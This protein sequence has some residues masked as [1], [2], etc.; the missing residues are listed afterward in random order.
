[1]TPKLQTSFMFTEHSQ[2]FFSSAD[3]SQVQY[4]SPLKSTFWRKIDMSAD[5]KADGAESELERERERERERESSSSSSSSSSSREEHGG[6]QKVFFRFFCFVLALD[7][8]MGS[9]LV[10]LNRGAAAPLKHLWVRR[11]LGSGSRCSQRLGLRTSREK[12][13]VKGYAATMVQE[14]GQ[15]SDETKVPGLPLLSVAPM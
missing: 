5:F 13:K 14:H 3:P 8:F 15:R 9:E 11:L 2:N 6:V 12:G 4:F 7:G 10:S 1:M